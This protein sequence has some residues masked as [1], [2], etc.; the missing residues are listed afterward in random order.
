M[1]ITMS[2]SSDEDPELIVKTAIGTFHNVTANPWAARVLP[3]GTLKKGKGTP[4][5]MHIKTFKVRLQNDDPR[6]TPESYRKIG[7]KLRLRAIEWFR[8]ECQHPTENRICGQ[9]PEVKFIAHCMS[10]TIVCHVITWPDL[11]PV[12]WESENEMLR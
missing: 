9:T 12:V 4:G 2:C 7:Q 10:T 5:G 8:R 11:D 3:S 1:F 6:L